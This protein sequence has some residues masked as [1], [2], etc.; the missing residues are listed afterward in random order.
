MAKAF[1]V[2]I[3]RLYMIIINNE[4]NLFKMNAA[5]YLRNN[6]NT[7]QNID[8]LIIFLNCLSNKLKTNL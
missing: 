2:F 7:K 4:A 1:R 8:F 3:I 5:L 6:L